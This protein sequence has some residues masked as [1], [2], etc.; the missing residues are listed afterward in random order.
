MVDQSSLTTPI[1]LVTN[2]FKDV[3]TGLS[4]NE[5]LAK[6]PECLADTYKLLIRFRSFLRA[7]VADI[8]K[9]Y[10]LVRRNLLT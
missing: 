3:A 1:R 8:M 2:S 4:V 10:Y 9:A 7:L 6:G 5:L